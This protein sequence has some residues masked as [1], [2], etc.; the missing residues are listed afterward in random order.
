MCSAEG[1][2]AM[3]K[4][5]DESDALTHAAAHG[6]FPHHRRRMIVDE[7]RRRCLHIFRFAVLSGLG[8]VLRKNECW[9]PEPDVHANFTRNL[10]L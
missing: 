7:V 2:R 10:F 1:E 6:H 3:E 4:L 5:L 8:Y 9:E